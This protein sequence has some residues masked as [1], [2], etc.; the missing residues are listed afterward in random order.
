[1]GDKDLYNGTGS[2]YV[3]Y[4]A[5]KVTTGGKGKEQ[6][7][8]FSIT[9]QYRLDPSKLVFLH[10]KAQ[11]SYEDLVIKP[12][13]TRIISDQATELEVLDFYSGKGRV[14]L[15]K[16]IEAAI[17]SHKNLSEVGIRVETFV[18]DRIELDAK[19][20]AEITGRQLA[21]QQK[22]RSIEEAKAAQ[23]NANKVQAVAQANKLKRIVEAEASKQEQIKGAEAN[24]ESR[25]LAAKAQAQEIKEKATAERFRKEQ[26]AKGALA[27]GLAQAKV[28]KEN[29]MSKYAGVAGAR[30]AAVEIEQAKS[31]RLKNANING[32]VTEKTFMMLTD[33]GNLN[34]KPQIT[35]QANK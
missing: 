8:S 19:F 4:P 31:D 11:N 21:T 33:G 29:K 13:L 1:M 14:A 17:T 3:D 25:I 30:Q 35:I 26:D 22:L 23:E 34:D 12:A 9:L 10:K 27:L 6:P 24:N 5:F 16:N 18:I 2:E 28:S 20:V 15:Q 7:A 32:V